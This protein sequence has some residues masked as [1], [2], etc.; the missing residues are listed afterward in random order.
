MNYD[1][2]S[3]E[4]T[5]M[6]KQTSFTSDTKNEGDSRR[7]EGPGWRLQVDPEGEGE[8]LDRFIS[9]RLPRVSRS[10]ASRLEVWRLSDDD[11]FIS[12][13]KKSVK[14]R[15]GELLWVKR[16]PPQ[17]D[18]S[19]LI[20]P[21]LIDE[22]DEFLV[23]DKPPGWVAHPTASRY[24]SAITTWLKRQG[25][26]AQPAHRLDAETSGVL[27]C[28][29][30]PK[31]ESEVNRLFLNHEVEKRYLAISR[32]TDEGDR[33]LKLGE[34]R[35]EERRP[36]GFDLH[37]SVGIK[38]GCGGL[39][40]YTS[41]ELID[42]WHSSTNGEHRCLIRA[43]PRTGRQ[44][45]IRVHL[46]LGGVPIIGDK[47]YG[48]DESYFLKHLNGELTENDFDELG[49][50]RQAL[51]AETLGFTWRGA[52]FEWSSQLPA[53]LRGLLASRAN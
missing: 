46:S 10:R 31:L 25:I 47:L 5:P 36:L 12:K 1:R 26:N 23:I 38:M 41:C 52:E 11:Q 50:H 2:L 45:Q 20:D 51:H 39:E 33:R 40:S 43:R 6:M 44:H 37:S 48:R 22:S 53:D 49:H 4:R 17:E 7:A 29:R 28:V 42:R 3:I 30:D 16:P 8:R 9:R 18:L 24:E 21:T 15:A 27:L 14:L 35:W 19:T 32:V 34:R 13:L